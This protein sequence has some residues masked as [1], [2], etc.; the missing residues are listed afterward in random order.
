ML[1][2]SIKQHT[3]FDSVLGTKQVKN[4]P[5]T[6]KIK[7]SLQP[8]ISE[9]IYKYIYIY[10]FILGPADYDNLNGVIKKI[11]KGISIPKVKNL[12]FKLYF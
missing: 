1:R 12:G 9:Y 2:S 11:H 5:K 6:Y 7:H 8:G 3:T 4:I 10:I